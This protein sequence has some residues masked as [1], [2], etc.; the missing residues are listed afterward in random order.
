MLRVLGVHGTGTYRYHRRT[1]SA[2]GAAVALGTDWFQHLG[3]AMPANSSVDLRLAYYGHQLGYELEEDPALMEPGEQA[4]LIQWAELLRP[5]SAPIT[6]A[7]DAAELMANNFGSATRLFALAFCRELYAYLIDPARRAACR[8]AVAAAISGHRPDVILAHSLGSAVAYEALWEHQETP[9]PLLLTVGSPLA[10]P[11]V[12][13]ETAERGRPPSVR[14]WINMA[15][16]TDIVAVAKV[17][18]PGAENVSIVAGMWEYQTPGA[19]LRSRDVTK[20]IF[21]AQTGTI[22]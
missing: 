4:L 20:A 9:V 14:R 13:P 6:D 5:G 10:M 7:R 8:E 16:V 18:F 3:T 22:V 21:D 15:D 12:L 2:E 11:G 1:G 19:Y 17:D